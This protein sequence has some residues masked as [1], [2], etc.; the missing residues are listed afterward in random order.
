MDAQKFVAQRSWKESEKIRDHF[1][2]FFKQI[3]PFTAAVVDAVKGS[4][5]L[6]RQMG[7]L[8][9][10]LHGAELS[11][12]M[13]EEHWKRMRDA[14]EVDAFY[15]VGDVSLT[16]KYIPPS[17]LPKTYNP[18]TRPTVVHNLAHAHKN[19]HR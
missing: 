19:K 17:D 18:N 9:R 7:K 2:D 3:K 16:G 6:Q 14:H 8:S 4:R 15:K 13:E 11:R 12:K 1:N 10:N 5:D